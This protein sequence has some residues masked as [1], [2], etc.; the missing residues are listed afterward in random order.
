M[1]YLKIVLATNFNGIDWWFKY[2]IYSA[3]PQLEDALFCADDSNKCIPDQTDSCLISASVVNQHP[4]NCTVPDDYDF[5]TFQ[6]CTE[7]SAQ[8]DSWI[9]DNSIFNAT[10]ITEFNLVCGERRFWQYFAFFMYGILFCL[11]YTVSLVPG[12]MIWRRL[13]IIW[14]LA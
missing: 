11:W 13:S 1:R 12:R 8:C 5:D 10:V 4:T 2:L 14:D 3:R 6:T 9:F 7:K